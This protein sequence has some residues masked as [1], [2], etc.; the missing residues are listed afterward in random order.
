V[1]IVVGEAVIALI[2]HQQS[3][4]KRSAR[5]KADLAGSVSFQ[6]SVRLC[7]SV[8]SDRKQKNSRRRAT[9]FHQIYL[10]ISAAQNREQ[11][12]FAPLIYDFIIFSG[13]P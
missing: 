6:T 11:T 9:R 10:Q 4:K 3:N 7:F 8:L 12:K 2:C 13:D 1:E 5:G